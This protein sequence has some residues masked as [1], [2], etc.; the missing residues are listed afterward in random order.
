METL[1]LA[2]KL[3]WLFENVRKPGGGKYTQAEVV[4]GSGGALTRVY[5]WK[6]RTGR[7]TNPSFQI[8]RAIAAFFQVD[9]G[10]F[11]ESAGKDSSSADQSGSTVSNVDEIM[12]GVS[13][14]SEEEQRVILE[15]VKVILGRKRWG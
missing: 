11:S 9:P 10:Y 2:E 15:L 7:A 13:Q 6:L 1:S 8:I 14:L 3:S 12:A 5:L 4:E